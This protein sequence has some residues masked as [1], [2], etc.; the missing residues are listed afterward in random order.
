MP[1][2]HLT[3]TAIDKAIQQC[4]KTSTTTELRDSKSNLLGTT[5]VLR[6]QA[7]RHT[8]QL[9]ST[10][11]LANGKRQAKRISLGYYPAIDLVE[12]RIKALT[13]AINEPAQPEPK[14]LRLTISEILPLY[15]QANERLVK[16][17][18]RSYLDCIKFHIAN[19]PISHKP[20]NTITALDVT[21][22]YQYWLAKG[23]SS[24]TSN[25]H[26][27]LT[28]ALFNFAYNNEGISPPP[29]FKAV[30]TIKQPSNIRTDTLSQQDIQAIGLGF[31]AGAVNARQMQFFILGL[32]LGMRLGE[33][34]QITFKMLEQR[35]IYLPT[36]KNKRPLSLPIPES[37]ILKLIELESVARPSTS[38]Y[39]TLL[40]QGIH[41][42]ASQ[43]A[44]ATNV[45]FSAH[46]LR[47][48][49]CTMLA[50]QGVDYFKI[51]M[52]LNHIG[53]D[54][55]SRHYCH[56]DYTDLLPDLVK[57]TD[58]VLRM[59]FNS[60]PKSDENI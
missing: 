8:W 25:L 52:V 21:A 13:T 38:R 48:T 60:D 55:T 51:K 15:L 11:T 26:L 29:V 56:L 44:S 32:C 20:I 43:I 30:A 3:Q 6:I 50:R 19:S 57:H 47:K 4:L 46:T 18:Q 9:H 7:K 37:L 45:M 49:C 31:K 14:K 2:L 34:R 16:T 22:L 5:L 33:L 23:L 42:Y 12:A 58:L 17:T 1:T 53:D 39:P 40:A 36:T 59:L 35:R 28:K 24:S 41:N 54:V 10:T 27:S